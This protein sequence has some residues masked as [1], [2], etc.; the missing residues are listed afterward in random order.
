MLFLKYVILVFFLLSFIII[1][2]CG[3]SFLIVL[4]YVII[5]CIKVILSY[6]DIESF[7]ELVILIV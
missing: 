2:V 6:F 1:L 3:I 7:L 5:F 4:E